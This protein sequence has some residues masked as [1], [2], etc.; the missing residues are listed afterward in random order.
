MRLSDVN[1]FLRYAELQPS[2]LTSIPFCRAYDY[3][4]F[5]VL[6]GQ[7]DFVLSDRTVPLSAGMLLYFRP[8]T[9]Y[10]FNGKVKVIVLNFDMTRNQSDKTD[11]ISPLETLNRFEP[12]RV[13]ENDP[14][15]E[16]K[17]VIVVENAF[18][19]ESR[20]QECL[21]HFCYPTSYSDAASS[22]I[23]KEILCYAVQSLRTQK[24]ELPEL[25]QR[26]ML[27][28]QQNYDREL[29]N[30]RLSDEFGYHSFY[31]NR[32][33]KRSMGITLHQAVIRERVSIAKRLLT[34]T[35]LPVDAVASEVGYSDRTQFSTAFRKATGYTPTEY[36]RIRNE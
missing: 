2:V 24:R 15:E 30:S 12:W 32:V 23:V 7:A 17:D 5:Y 34:S 3:R 16:L 35:E 13:F 33:F 36:R 8:E 18:E 31:L 9:A 29:S 6:E 11:P 1:P 14:P 10:Y 21:L 26:V 25:V 22:A 19:M 20:M 4:L 27:Y 28:I